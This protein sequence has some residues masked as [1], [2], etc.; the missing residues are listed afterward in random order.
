MTRT[1]GLHALADALH[2]VQVGQL[3]IG[4]EGQGDGR[5]EATGHTTTLARLVFEGDLNAVHSHGCGGAAPA[6]VGVELPHGLLDQLVTV[7]VHLQGQ[8]T[9]LEVTE[10]LHLPAELR[11]LHLKAPQLGQD[12]GTGSDRQD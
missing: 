6:K 5:V 1:A 2:T 7:T 4:Q 8:V 11:L 12:L 3:V 9:R 10:F